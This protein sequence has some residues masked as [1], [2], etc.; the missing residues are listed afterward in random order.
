MST[1]SSTTVGSIKKHSVY[2]DLEK[3]YEHQHRK[4]DIVTV[5]TPVTNSITACKGIV[6]ALATENK[7]VGSSRTHR[8]S[9]RSTSRH[10]K[11]P[12]SHRVSSTDSTA[13]K[14]KKVNKK[15]IDKQGPPT[16]YG[17]C[18][19]EYVGL[20]SQLTINVPYYGEKARLTIGAGKFNRY[21]I[22]RP[23]F[24]TKSENSH[25]STFSTHSSLHAHEFYHN[26]K[27][28]NFYDHATI[29]Q[30]T[31][32]TAG[33]SYVLRVFEKDSQWEQFID[34]IESVPTNVG[35]FKYCKKYLIAFAFGVVMCI[36]FLIASSHFNFNIGIVLP[37]SVLYLF[38]STLFLV[39]KWSNRANEVRLDA[40][41]AFVE[42]N[43]AKLLYEYKLG[44]KLSQPDGMR[45][46]HVFEREGYKMKVRK[47]T[48]LCCCKIDILIP[49]GDC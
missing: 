2:P 39:M 36:A 25:S 38:F 34:D 12:L 27:L 32:G 23:Y 4:T 47:S 13:D 40:V 28:D 29:G 18:P 9:H 37:L 14:K 26:S 43:E 45:W 17:Q 5:G 8:T 41:Q 35:T 7:V 48:C 11:T 15:K 21:Q 24:T 33:N 16:T 19:P 42:S 44:A 30:N 20:P 6:P 1:N 49:K 22:P 3:G 10:Q 31:T 46:A